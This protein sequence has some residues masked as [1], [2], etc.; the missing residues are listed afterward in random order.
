MTTQHDPNISGETYVRIPRDSEIAPVEFE[1]QRR[2]ISTRGFASPMSLVYGFAILAVIGSILLWLPWASNTP[3]SVNP[4]TALFTAVSAITVTGLA[5]VDTDVVWSGFGQGVILFLIFIGGL[6]FMTGT[7]FLLILFG[8]ELGLRNRLIIQTGLGGGALSGIASTVRNIFV[9]SVAIQVAGFAALWLYWN[10]VRDVWGDLD[11]VNN[12]WQ[13]LF[14]A[15]SS[16][17]NAGMDIM[18]DDLVGGASLAGFRTDYGTLALTCALIVLG[19]LGYLVIN[20]IW[21]VKRFRRF[22]LETKVVLV[23]TALLLVFGVVT[24]MAEWD[25][26]AT[27]GDVGIGQRVA[28][29]TFHSVVTR[30]AGFS[31]IDYGE[32]QGSTD[33]TTELLMFVGAASGST[34][35]GIK[36]NTFVII[37]AAVAITMSGRSA[38]NAFGRQLPAPVVTRALA[39]GLSA[40]AI[41]F[42]LV[43]ALAI[44]E[45]NLPFRASLFEVV[46]A[47]GTVGLSTGVTSS[48]GAAGQI[49][50]VIAMFL[51]RFGPLTLGLLMAGSQ[52]NE[53]FSLPQEEVRIG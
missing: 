5:T 49:I 21:I 15:V 38:V 32:A 51:G 46:S 13:A 42:A 2:T 29:A 20:D 28:D 1:V 47:F 18:P 16:F 40:I 22:A 19:G 26:P 12:V 35:G 53:R 50:I 36:V 3:G 7:A 44:A 41:V 33:L 43:F 8:Q 4:L 27:S 30:S 37:V 6:G 11:I 9:L 25:N 10:L 14:H 24:Y 31:V 17:N 45:D 34:G 52:V 39:V 23:G 48:L